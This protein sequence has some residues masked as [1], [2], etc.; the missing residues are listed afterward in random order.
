[1]KIAFLGAGRVGA[2][3]AR[4]LAAAGHDVALAVSR[5]GSGSVQAALAKSP[6]LR[7]LPAEEAVR[8]S[9]CVFLATPFQANESIIAPLSEALAGKVLIDC[10]NPVGPGLSHGLGSARSG[11]ELLQ[12]LAPKAHVV[13]AFSIYGYENFEDPAYP[14]HSVKPA[15]LFCGD[16]AAAKAKAAELIAAVGFDPVDVGGLVQALHLEHMTLLWVRMV[17]GGGQSPG[18]VWAALRR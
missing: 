17:R 16:D 18:I 4:H 2:P 6:R 14:G 11:S 8:A 1:M 13:K 15:M 3:L 9:E 7:A 12:A 5:E 10:T